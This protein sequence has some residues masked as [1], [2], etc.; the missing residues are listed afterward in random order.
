MDRHCSGLLRDKPKPELISELNTCEYECHIS[1][2]VKRFLD[3]HS[4][5][6]SSTPPLSCPQNIA[7]IVEVLNTREARGLELI[8]SRPRRLKAP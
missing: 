2:F 5:Y 4:L 3:D 8:K 6:V 7:A 1:L